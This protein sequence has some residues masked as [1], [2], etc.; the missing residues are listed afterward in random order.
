MGNPSRSRCASK[1]TCGYETLEPRQFL[2]ASPLLSASERWHAAPAAHHQSLLHGHKHAKLQ[3]AITATAAHPMLTVKPLA[4]GT[5]PNATTATAPY[6]PQQ[7][8]L[9]YGFDALQPAGGQA[10]VVGDGSGQTIAIVDAYNDPHALS[11]LQAFDSAFGLPDPAFMQ[12]DATGAAP[13][14]AADAGWGLETALDVEWA[15]AIAPRANI[16]LVEA[17]SNS[18]LDLLSAVDY[19]KAH[20][21][22]VSM[23]WGSGEF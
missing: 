22:V 15:H 5:Q 14:M 11:D 2:S 19:A 20:A 9:A 16:L 6:T 21:S 7:I 18:T 8:R 12:V 17:K 1:V 23:S 10:P 4:A 13:T 3:T